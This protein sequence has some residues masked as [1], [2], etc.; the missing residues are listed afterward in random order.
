MHGNTQFYYRWETCMRCE[1][2]CRKRVVPGRESELVT[3]LCKKCTKSLRQKQYA[4]IYPSRRSVEQ[5]YAVRRTA[6]AHR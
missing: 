1:K 6:E 3:I 4:R 2:R 5:G